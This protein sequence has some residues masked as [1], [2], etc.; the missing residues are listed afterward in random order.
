[1]SKFDIDKQWKIHR[2]NPK[3]LIAFSL[4]GD[5]PK[6]T[7]GAVQNVLLANIVYPNW[8][9]RFYVDNS[10]P[11]KITDELLELGA[12]VYFVKSNKNIKKRQRS[13]W[14]F[15]AL[16]EVCRVI[17]R[18]TDSRVNTR[19]KA[20]IQNWLKSGK[21]YSRIW[22][23]EHREDGHANPLMGG[24]WGAVSVTPKDNKMPDNLKDY[25]H[26]LWRTGV[27]PLFPKIEQQIL[28]WKVEGYRSDEMFLIKYI[29]PKFKGR[30][31]CHMAGCGMDPVP[32]PYF[33]LEETGGIKYVMKDVKL[34]NDEDRTSYVHIEYDTNKMPKLTNRDFKEIMIQ[35]NNKG[36]SIGDPIEI[37]FEQFKRKNLYEYFVKSTKSKAKHC[38]WFFAY[39]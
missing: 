16:G 29:V 30:I 18:D 7:E 12:Q 35:D 37:D 23:A 36:G 2:T 11:K 4:Y 26:N 14:R 3:L 6:Y 39:K 21:T 10:V 13:L 17:F 28:S 22:D 24:M 27:K 1:M 34:K 31:N 19:E 8:T 32:F 9:C 15:L 33:F 20:V 38:R 5:N 25:D